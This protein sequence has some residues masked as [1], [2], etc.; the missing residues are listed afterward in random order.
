MER[1]MAEL[2][3][4]IVIGAGPGGLTAAIYLAREGLKTVIL[5]K[6][7]PGGQVITTTQ[8]ENY[9]GFPE[10]IYGSEL[11]AKIERQVRLLGIE[12]KTPFLSP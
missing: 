11:M 7:S 2:Y 12:I 1:E 9:P 4:V 5:E 10:G 6:F 3:D 8:V